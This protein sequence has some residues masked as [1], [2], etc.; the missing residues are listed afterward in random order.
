[1]TAL[2]VAA[3]LAFPVGSSLYAD[4]AHSHAAHQA[5]VYA[6]QHR[7]KDAAL[8][9]KL[10]RVP[11]AIWF[12][13]GDT[14]KQT[15]HRAAKLIRRAGS[16]VPVLVVYNIPNRD[17]GHYSK[18]GARHYRRWIDGFAGG[19]G[20]GRAIVILEPDALAGLCG[21]HRIADL[22]HAVDRL[23]R[24]P[25]A[26]V[27]VDAGHS[28]WQPAATMA[29]RLAKVHATAFS[30]NVANFRSNHESVAYGNEISQRLNGAHFVIDTS[31]NGRGPR[32]KEWCNPPGRGLGDRPT[33]TTYN[34]TVDALL[35][36][37]V[38]G[39]SDGTCRHGPAAGTW[40]PMYALGLARR[41]VPAL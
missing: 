39:E 38:P 33:T 27:Y 34:P 9:R 29:K 20:D 7:N 13:G 31:R 10:A 23:H 4:P 25:G 6:K 35:W 2:L 30:L 22:R 32:H 40:W 41:A 16:S 17:C 15:R 8:M 14:P 19:I 18:G 24:H 36:I 26:A 28:R 11:Q 37:K 12:T 5:R 3:A 21:T 1:V